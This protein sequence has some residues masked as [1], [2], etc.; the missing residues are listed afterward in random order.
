MNIQPKKM[1]LS[2]PWDLYLPTKGGLRRC[3]S[4]ECAKKISNKKEVILGLIDHKLFSAAQ[5]LD[6]S[7]S[8]FHD[9]FAADVYIHQSCYIKFVINP[10]EPKSLDEEREEKEADILSLFKYKIRTKII[11]DKEA[12]LLHELLI[13]VSS[14]STEQ[15]LSDSPIRETRTL[16][17]FLRLILLM[18]FPCF[19]QE[20]LLLFMLVL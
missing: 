12:F 16:R 3:D 14:I 8:G 18:I 15:E 6:I 7:L 4:S 19:N 10:V 9:I 1:C 2:G 5:R 11:R 17:R 20:S 13:D